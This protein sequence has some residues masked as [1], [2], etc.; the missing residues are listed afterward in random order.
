MILAADAPVFLARLEL[1]YPRVERVEQGGRLFA[2]GPRV[3]LGEADGGADVELRQ[4]V[5]HGLGDAFL[6]DGVVDVAMGHQ[7]HQLFGAVA[8]HLVDVDGVAYLVAQVAQAEDVGRVLGHVDGLPAQVEQA[9]DEDGVLVRGGLALHQDLSAQHDGGG[10]QEGILQL[11]RGEDAVGDDV[12][13]AVGQ[14]AQALVEGHFGR[15]VH[16]QPVVARKGLYQGVVESG[17]R[18]LVHVEAHGVIFHRGTQH[19]LAGNLRIVPR[20][21]GGSFRFARTAREGDCQQEQQRGYRASHE[22]PWPP[23]ETT[24]GRNATCRRRLLL[25]VLWV[26]HGRQSIIEVPRDAYLQQ[27]RV[28]GVMRHEEGLRVAHARIDMIHHHEDACALQVQVQVGVD[29]GITA[30]VHLVILALQVELLRGRHVGGRLI[31][32]EVAHVGTQLQ[33]QYF[34]EFG[35]QVHVVVERQVGQRQDGLVA[36]LLPRHLVVQVENTQLKI[37]LQHSRNHLYVPPMLRGQGV[38]VEVG[39]VLDVLHA[40]LQVGAPL[41]DVQLTL[42]AGAEFLA[43]VVV[44]PREV[45]GVVM[46]HVE[47]GQTV[48]DVP[49]SIEVDRVLAEAEIQ[50][51]VALH[52]ELSCRLP[53]QA[54]FARRVVV[55]QRALPLGQ[56]AADVELVFGVLQG[57]RSWQG[58]VHVHQRVSAEVVRDV[59]RQSCLGVFVEALQ[60]GDAEDVLHAQGQ[61]GVVAGALL[62]VGVFVEAVFARRLGGCAEGAART[63]HLE[64]VYEA[65]DGHELFLHDGVLGQGG[66]V[67]LR[68]P[69]CRGVL[70]VLQ[71]GHFAVEAEAVAVRQVEVEV[72]VARACPLQPGGDVL[73]AAHV[74]HLFGMHDVAVVDDAAVFVHLEEVVV[75]GGMQLVFLAD[76]AGKHARVEVRGGLVGVVTAPVQI[77]NV[78]SHGQPLIDVDREIGLEAVFAIDFAA[79]LVVGQVGEGDVAVG[80]EQ[81]AGL[82]VEAGQGG[83]EDGGVFIVVP[84]EE[85]ARLAG[86]AEVAQVVVV[87]LHASSQVG[88]LEVQAGRVRG[89]ERP[90]AQFAADFPHI[91][92]RGQAL[93]VHGAVLQVVGL[94]RGVYLVAILVTHVSALVH[95]VHG[96][97]RACGQHP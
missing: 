57:R 76:I 41:L 16:P 11:A 54:H 74:F 60:Q 24:D 44:V 49:A 26:L 21:R 91:E 68:Q 73:R 33:G 5:G 96:H 12:V 18:V 65:G 50:V 52:L 31:G 95:R 51:D 20:H 88:V 53:G 83:D 46:A 36:R 47:G 64:G 93:D 19:T 8:S 40:H 90:L 29:N 45:V 37:L 81:V 39:V 28:N 59:C 13:R 97:L 86:R 82:H 87:S 89:D 22:Q 63:L 7:G 70:R 58:R 92:F 6:A 3:E 85:D 80:E 15:D 30:K 84:L 56:F 43:H 4:A 9:L 42:H 14:P 27:A 34:E 2:D 48:A 69:L 71:L 25:W 32:G 77:V 55:Q 72:V 75:I 10:Q 61:G 78:K 35:Q 94:Q 66:A 79:R 23:D 62:Q 38:L 1:R 67:L 17:Q